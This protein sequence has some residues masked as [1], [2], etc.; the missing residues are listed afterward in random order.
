M[1][2]HRRER[3]NGLIYEE[4]TLLL[5][6]EVLDPRVQLVTVTGVE[7]T[8]DRRTARIYVACYTGEEDLAQGLQGLRSASSF[9]RS[10]LAQLLDWPFA[11]TLE[12]KVDRSWQRGAK[13]DA[14]LEALDHESGEEQDTDEGGA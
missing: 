13:V 9:L 12:F 4:L 5:K 2:G 10:R 8:L 7:L 14:L 3:A 6:D 1:T 11:P